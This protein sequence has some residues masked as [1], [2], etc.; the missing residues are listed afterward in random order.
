MASFNQVLETI[1]KARNDVKW[2]D[3][4]ELYNIEGQSIEELDSNIVRILYG[5]I[6]GR[7]QCPKLHRI[8]LDNE[9]R[10]F[11]WLLF[12]YSRAT[13]KRVEDFVRWS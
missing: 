13:T 7:Y 12:S 11:I 9:L 5:E 4:N 8:W 6:T 10:V 3:I 1:E 2:D